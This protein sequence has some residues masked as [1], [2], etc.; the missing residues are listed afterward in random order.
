MIDNSIEKLVNYALRAGLIEE[1]DRVWA[2][3]SLIASLGLESFT[4]PARTEGPDDIE[5][6]LAELL[7]F[8]VEKGLIDDSITEKDL[9]DARLMGLLTPRP[10]EVVRSFR[11]KYTESPRARTT[12][13]SR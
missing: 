13:S 5:S 9:F 7:A 4:R 8:A 10:S 1:E 2:E 12:A 3:N 11:A 6:I